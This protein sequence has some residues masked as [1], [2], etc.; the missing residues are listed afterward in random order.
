MAMFLEKQGYKVE[1]AE[2][3]LRALTL[4]EDHVPDVVFIDLVMPNISGEKLCQILR[5]QRRFD[6]SYCIVLSAISSEEEVDYQSYGFDACI[7]K[8]PL[9]SLGETILQVIGKLGNEITRTDPGGI[10]GLEH[11]YRREIT[12]ELLS[13]KRHFELILG[14]MAESLLETTGDGKVVF[15]NPAAVDLLGV[16]EE[17]LLSVPIESLFEENRDAIGAQLR[18]A[19]SDGATQRQTVTRDQRILL[20]QM[21]RVDD[22]GEI[23]LVVLIEDATERMTAEATIERSSDRERSL[24]FGCGNGPPSSLRRTI[25][26][27][28]KS[29][30]GSYSRK[31]SGDLSRR[32]RC[33]LMRCI[34]ESR[35]I[36]RSFPAC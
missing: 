36:F 4:L 14:N 15:A 25:L 13:K 9:T 26:S 33:F 20:V 31:S 29:A 12:R 21:L 11:L 5:S 18:T 22:D 27:L 3:G 8:G 28:L 16:P 23:S 24:R 10:F 19:L 7:A 2:D 1:S 30:R 17:V 35:I 32:R 34:T 6:E